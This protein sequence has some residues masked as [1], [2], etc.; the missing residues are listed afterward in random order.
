MVGSVT[1]ASSAPVAFRS[2]AIRSFMDDCEA[3]SITDAKSFTYPTGCA[4]KS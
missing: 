4:G 3:G 2:R 1:T